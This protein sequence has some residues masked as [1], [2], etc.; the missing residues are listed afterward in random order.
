MPVPVINKTQSSL[1]I[2]VN[3]AF[4]FQFVATESPTSWAIGPNELVPTG[5]VFNTASGLLTGSGQLPGIWQLTLTASNN[6]GDSIPEVFTFGIFETG[7]NTATQAFKTMKID[8][9]YWTVTLPDPA[10]SK[11]ITSG[12][13][14]TMLDDAVG[15]A[16]FGDD[17]LFKIELMSGFSAS[18]MTLVSARFAMR[19]TD[20]EPPFFTTSEA[21]FKVVANS[22]GGAIVYSYWLY[23]SLEDNALSEF[24]SDTNSDSVA[25]ANVLCEVEMMFNRPQSAPGPLLQ[26]ITTIPFLMRI[27][28]DSVR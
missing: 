16:R 24:L 19:G 6:S 3:Q 4:T 17:L 18:S 10:P 13:K 15:Q 11:T 28:E 27:R 23:V 22:V 9:T 2:A 21:A 14:D 5:F 25:E 7:V 1:S 12:G 8:T 20:T 26:K